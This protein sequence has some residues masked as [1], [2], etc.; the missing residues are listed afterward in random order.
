MQATI[1]FIVGVIL[2]LIILA[3]SHR[4]G[5][6]AGEPAPRPT[7]L[8]WWTLAFG[9]IAAA[10]FAFGLLLTPRGDSGSRLLL[11]SITFAS[12]AVVLGVGM[13]VRRDRR[14]PTW[15]GLV[16]GVAIALF[17]IAFAVGYILGIG[18]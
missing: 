9:L 5:A 15:V 14:W 4:W 6:A 7:I 17:W 8:S 1:S 13:L 12:A 2:A 10:A 18:E 11:V 3:M 16:V